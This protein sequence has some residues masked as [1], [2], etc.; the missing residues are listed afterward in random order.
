MAARF[1]LI[2]IFIAFMADAVGQE[3][4]AVQPARWSLSYDAGFRDENGAYAGGSEIM[5]IEIVVILSEL[6][7]SHV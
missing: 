2:F 6:N 4:D 1:A 7:N 3:V 5:H